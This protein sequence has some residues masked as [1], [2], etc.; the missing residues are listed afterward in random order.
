MLGPNY[1]GMTN[2]MKRFVKFGQQSMDNDEHRRDGNIAA[3]C[4]DSE[5]H[6][7]AWVV[8]LLQETNRLYD[9][10]NKGKRTWSVLQT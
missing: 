3:T 10:K 5:R 9:R 7:G 1:T 2:W 6:S 8:V 4:E